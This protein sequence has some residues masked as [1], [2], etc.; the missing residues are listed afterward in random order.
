[1]NASS[2]VSALGHA[3]L[4]NAA[5]G[6]VE[7]DINPKLVLVQFAIITVLLLVLKPMLFDPLL[8]LFEAREK[9][10][11]GARAEARKMDDRA[12]DILRKYDGEIQKVHR[13]AADERD[14]LRAEAQK[15]EAAEMTEA[16]TETTAIVESG[17][18]KLAAHASEMETTLKVA[19]LDLTRDI[20]AR[21]LGREVS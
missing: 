20:A 9:R 5:G 7:V 10:I 6:A 8:A 13:A 11:E 3:R 2:I 21:V 14:R 19:E 12:A 18:K 16:K 1:M 4:F 15:L 17:R